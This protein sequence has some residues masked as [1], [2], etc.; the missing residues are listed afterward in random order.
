MRRFRFT[1]QDRIKSRKLFD[2][3]FLFGKR[4]DSK[5]KLIRCNYLLINSDENYVKIGISIAKRTGKAV[6]RNRVRRIIREIY[7]LNNIDLKE[8]IKNTKYS[9]SIIFKSNRLN[10][11]SYPKVNFKLLEPEVTSILCSIKSVLD[12]N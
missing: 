3:T 1:R 2:E 5:N 10:E 7:R 6:W 11:K 4:L 12:K 8:K 9:L